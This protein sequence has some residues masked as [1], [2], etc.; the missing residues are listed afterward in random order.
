MGVKTWRSGP[1]RAAGNLICP[2]CG[3]EFYRSP[4]NRRSE[5]NYCSR[6]CM[7]KA[8]NGR[9]VGEKSPRWKGT[10]TRPCDN[11]GKPVS[12]PLWFASQSEMTFCDHACF[13]EWK[14]RNW[15]G[16]DN[17][18]WR[19]GRAPYYGANWKRQQ[20]EA[21]RRDGHKCRYCGVDESLCRRALDV[22]HIVP[23]R[24]FDKTQ[25]KQANALSN[26]VSLCSS[27]HAYAER[28]SKTGEIKDWLALQ[29]AMIL[30]GASQKA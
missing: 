17:P 5:I 16:E 11:C 21:R 10:D 9:F 27:C 18:C 26:L 25:T 6:D 2:Q 23:F 19:G 3:K 14:A 22:H 4:A 13:G 8:F 7:A 24:M 20:R 28:A 15:T 30:L 12:R 29:E 1:Q